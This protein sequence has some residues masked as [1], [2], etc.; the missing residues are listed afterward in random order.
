MANQFKQ[1]L[2]G[3]VDRYPD[4]FADVRG[5]GL[6][7]GLKCVVPNGEVMNRLRDHNVLTVVAGDNALRFCRH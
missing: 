6:L 3:I 5:L 7:A 2:A 4:V 1:G